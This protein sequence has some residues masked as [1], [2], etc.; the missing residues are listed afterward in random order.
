ML[1]NSRRLSEAHI[2]FAAVILRAAFDVS[3]ALGE[4]VQHTRPRRTEDITLFLSVGLAGIAR[5]LLRA[6]QP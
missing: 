1:S 5:E 6:A 4:C 2:Q 3:G